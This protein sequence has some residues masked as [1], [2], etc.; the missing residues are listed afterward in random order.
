MP[1]TG[2]YVGL[3][4]N[5]TGSRLKYAYGEEARKR[6]GVEGMVR[7]E[8][9]WEAIQEFLASDRLRRAT[10]SRAGF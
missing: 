3:G 2:G 8:W 6:Y 10:V 9:A 7:Q 4:K 1:E 5:I